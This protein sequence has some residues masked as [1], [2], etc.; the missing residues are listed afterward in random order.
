MNAVT[1]YFFDAFNNI[2]ER[3]ELG[4]AAVGSID[5]SPIRADWKPTT[6]QDT[7]IAGPD[8][9]ELVRPGIG[10][11]IHHTGGGLQR[12]TVPY[13][14]RRYSRG[15]AERYLVDM[16]T[17]LGRT[18]LGELS[19]HG[20]AY[21]NCWFVSGDGNII[22]AR[23]NAPTDTEDSTNRASFHVTGSLHFVRGLP[24]A[25]DLGQPS[26]L[27]PAERGNL[28]LANDGDYTATVANGPFFGTTTKI[29]RYC[30]LMS[31]SVERPF[32]AVPIPRCDGVRIVGRG[33]TQPGIA[34]QL[35]YRRG[36]SVTLNMRG[37]VWC[38][39][40]NE[41][42]PDVVAVS[43]D[44]VTN[45]SRLVLERRILELQLAL[46]GERLNLTGNGNTF[47]DCFLLSLAPD[48]DTEAYTSLGFN[49]RFEQELNE[50][51]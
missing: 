29:G 38:Y 7:V 12:I 21:T 20:A 33:H 51:S 44:G 30:D 23:T 8:G 3:M 13:H 47:N 14:A 34:S 17:H 24:P 2:H 15:D 35:D 1:G 31:A 36:R 16:L 28:G 45:P 22:H 10:M 26:S 50:V 27:P 9:P 42:L 6:T 25:L 4:P 41:G 11:K 40:T 43:P 37:V 48:D 49:A 5:L 18:D 32:L 39:Q 46:R 19:V